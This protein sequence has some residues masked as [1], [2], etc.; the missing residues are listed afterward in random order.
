MIDQLRQTQ[1]NHGRNIFVMYMD[2]IIQ[3]LIDFGV[4]AKNI[5][6][7]SQE[8]VRYLEEELGHK[9]P[10]AYI[11]FMKTMGHGVG[12]SYF[13]DADMLYKYAKAHVVRN[14]EYIQEIN[15]DLIEDGQKDLIPNDAYFFA[16]DHGE[17]YQNYFRLNDPS[18]DPAV[19]VCLHLQHRK[20][21][22][23]FTDFVSGE[24]EDT[25]KYIDIM[26]AFDND[27]VDDNDMD[28]TC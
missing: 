12:S 6:G 1:I 10:D 23:K 16:Y 4:N 22:D 2:K 21:A 24:I 17:H 5:R 13:R 15:E 14:N 26:N 27:D 25:K 19:Y 8:E 28:Q 7:C 20:V 9:L 3:K 18:P 11:E